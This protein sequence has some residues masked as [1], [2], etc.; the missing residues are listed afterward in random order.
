MTPDVS[1]PSKELCVK[2]TSV[3]GDDQGRVNPCD[4]LPPLL[5]VGKGLLGLW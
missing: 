5:C 3:C 4:S 1:A 2:C